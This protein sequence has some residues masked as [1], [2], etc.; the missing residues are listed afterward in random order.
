MPKL[1]LKIEIKKAVKIKTSPNPK[2]PNRKAVNGVKKSPISN[3]LSPDIRSIFKISHDYQSN[4]SFHFL[5]L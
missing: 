1:P 5:N 2:K 3:I 4:S